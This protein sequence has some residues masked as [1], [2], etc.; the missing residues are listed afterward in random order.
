NPASPV[1][2]GSTTGILSSALRGIYVQGRYAYIASQVNTGSLLII[3]ISKPASPV[4]VN[5]SSL[6][7][8]G[9]LN[10]IYVQGRYAYA[11][12]GTT[13]ATSVQII[14]VSTPSAPVVIGTVPTAAGLT[15]FRLFVQGRYV[16]VINQGSTGAT[17]FQIFDVGGAYI[18]QLE[19]GGI[20]T[21]T[22]QTRENMTVN[23]DLAVVGGATFGRGFEATGPCG[24]TASG[25]YAGAS[26]T[27][28]GWQPA[29]N[30]SG[31]LFVPPIVPPSAVG[32]VSTNVANYSCIQGNYVYQLGF[33]PGSFQVIDV[34]NP[35]APVIVGTST[36]LGGGRGI[37]VQGRYAYVVNQSPNSLVIFD[38]SNPV[39]PTQISSTNT[40][41]TPLSIYVQ[42]R[43]AYMIVGNVLQIYD[44]SNPQAPVFV[45][46]SAA[47][48]TPQAV[49]VQG[50]YAYVA[51]RNTGNTFNIYDV[52]NPSAPVLK[53]S[54]ATGL[55]P[56]D[57]YVQGRY[58]YVVN[59]GV[60]SVQIFD[61]KD[62]SNPTL[63]GAITVGGSSIVVQG[64][65][66]YTANEATAINI[67]DVSNPSSPIS[68]GSITTAT[69]NFRTLVQGRYAYASTASSLQVFDL[70]GAYIQQLEAGGIEVGTLATRE[71][72]T[73]NNDLAVVGGATFGR[74][75]ESTGPSSITASGSYTSNGWQ[76][77]LNVS[78][79]LF[80]PPMTPPSAVGSLTTGNAPIS[81][82]VQG[83]YAYVVNNTSSTLQIIDVSNPQNPVSINGATGTATT[84]SGPFTVYVQ[85]RYAYISGGAG[86]EIQDVSNPALPVFVG[87]VATSNAQGLYVQDK[88]VYVA[89]TN[90]TLQVIDVSNPPSP[91][92]VGAPS[93]GTQL[94]EVYVQGKYA[95]VTD[96]GAGK[97][98]VVDISN[99]A[100][101]STVGSLTTASGS[102]AGIYVQGR[103]AYVTNQ[104]SGTTNFQIVDISNPSP[105]VVSGSSL[106]LTGSPTH[107]YVQGRYAYVVSQTSNTLQIIDVTIP[108]APVVIGSVPAGSIPFRVFVQGRY[109]YVINQGSTGTTGFQIFDVGGAY[110]Q[111]LEAGGIETGTLQT[112]ENMTVNNDLAVVGGA[113]FARGF[114]AN[115][116]SAITGSSF[117]ASPIPALIL[118]GSAANAAS[119][120]LRLNNVP[121]VAASGTADTALTLDSANNVKTTTALTVDSSQNVN[122]AK[123]LLMPNTISSTVGIIEFG[124]SRFISNIG[125]D[126]TFVGQNAG[127]TSLTTV[128][129]LDNTGVG[130][131][132]LIALTVGADNT[133]IGS[134]AGKL[135]KDGTSNTC[136]GAAAGFDVVTP[137]IGISSGS[138]N[139]C[140]GASAGQGITTGTDNICIGTLTGSNIAAGIN[141]IYIGDNTNPGSE[142]NALRIGNGTT[143]AFIQGI[144]GVLSSGGTAVFINGSN[145]L[146]TTTSSHRY[147]KDI[148]DLASVKEA[149]KKLRPV[150]FKYI[151]DKAGY[152][153]YGLIAEEVQKI[154]PE[155][156]IYKDG[157]P[158]T[159]RYHLF[160]AIFIKALQELIAQNEE[161]E[162]KLADQ[163]ERLEKQ[164]ILQKYLMEEVARLVTRSE[165]R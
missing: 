153:E 6:N 135:I 28:S 44:V 24:I 54:V 14:D 95:Y 55:D 43:Y 148:V 99:P 7:I 114:E 115:G 18:Q 64:R 147:K 39:A 112:R 159:I 156:V 91:L 163:H 26:F 47:T 90:G 29:L 97:L 100:S 1:L 101:P 124:G 160:D 4:L 94:V 8:T 105:S 66:A 92:L 104:T 152:P 125:T 15:P 65:Y 21:G 52:S 126:N 139:T 53:A 23:N 129:A 50:T 17:G 59:D 141:N 165:N 51:C 34:S 68:A 128:D 151:A 10:G 140:I 132:A 109:V 11:T 71:N 12:N 73:V 134:E 2:A 137:T 138:S 87:S 76:P 86:L 37:T 106:T 123:N 69:G 146:G 19:A 157:Q 150:T 107:I 96:H 70:G 81:V 158:E 9:G 102:T 98:L 25:S 20:E 149:L 116:P 120:P 82:Y 144:D 111:Q 22:L 117:A 122:I 133:A 56:L 162:K 83:R 32:T 130:F 49:Y 161:L 3:D 84:L 74:G 78:G 61:V 142:S 35:S 164:E 16:Y 45:A 67:I 88:Y 136:I 40:G 154:F 121:T 33:T 113:T 30:V 38:V 75:F 89:L 77:A 46:S 57:V 108:S 62:P 31:Q 131:N 110:I 145:Q 13:G 58:A 155:L 27:A 93:L 103:Y 5:G 80:V 60:P 118:T 72:M 41:S 79:Q 42:G 143:T 48:T 63:V 36:A 85:G 127:N 119:T